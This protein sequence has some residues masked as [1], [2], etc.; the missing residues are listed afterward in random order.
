MTTKSR[1]AEGA[2]SATVRSETPGAVG[3]LQRAVRVLEVL[4]AADQPQSVRAVAELTGLSKSAVQRLM[5]EL[6]S[7]DLATQDPVSRR[8][9][10]GPRALALGVAYQRRMDVRQAALPHMA[11]LRDATDETVGLSVALADQLLHVDQ[12]ESTLGLHARLDIGRPLPLWSG[13]PA[14]LL[15]AVRPDAE[16]AEIV[17]QRK[18]ADLVPVNPPDPEQLLQEVDA[19]RRAGHARAFEETLPGVN[20]MSVPVRGATGDLMAVLSV[21]APSIRL[22]AETMDRLLPQVTATA[23]AISAALGWRGA[24]GLPEPRG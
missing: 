18:H 20:T 22:P 8:Y 24:M 15:L 23:E 1:R 21:T 5:A 12:V 17:R 16:I 19:V 7:V 13:A 11:A 10:L 3:V 2:S 14:R 4:A 6:V 9:R